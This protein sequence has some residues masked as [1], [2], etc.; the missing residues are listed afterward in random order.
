VTVYQ[1][2]RRIAPEEATALVGTS[3]GREWE[4]THRSPSDE[5]VRFVEDGETVALITVLPKPL[6]VRLRILLRGIRF[7]EGVARHSLPTKGATFGYAPKKPIG[8][9][10]GCRLGAFGRDNP[11]AEDLLEEIAV[12]LGDTFA[13]LM[14]ERAQADRATLERS[15][16]N[17]WRLHGDSLW[18]SGVIN[19]ANVLPYHRDGNNLATWSAM[20]TLR[21]GM[22]G[23]RLHLPEYGIVFPCGDGDV[24]WFYGRGLVHGV[25]PMR[26]KLE[27]GYRYSVVFY[28]LQ[29]LKDC[30]T[31]A[32]ETAKVAARRTQRE[33][34]E[35][36][37]IREGTY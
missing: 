25:T 24:T 35:A 36:E 15:V 20:P 28:A 4:P 26:R 16:L 18:T 7:G 3:V 27:D 30:A 23:G 31:Y 2:T 1:V 17:D 11:A 21:Y 22:A 34:A 29:G 14:P 32:E 12:N 8:G 33:R 6:K 9:Q 10:E 37:R 19:D 5:P 13:E